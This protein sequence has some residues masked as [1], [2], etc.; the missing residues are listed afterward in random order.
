MGMPIYLF[1]YLFIFLLFGAVPVAYGGSQAR[2]QIGGTA[3]G[4]RHSHNN[5]RFWATSATYSTAHGNTGSL[6]QWARPGIEPATSW[7]LVWF[8]STVPQQ[9]LCS[10]PLSPALLLFPSLPCSSFASVLLSHSYQA[11]HDPLSAWY[12]GDFSGFTWSPLRLLIML[13]SF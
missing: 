6:T 12:H 9:E 13:N 1:I 11:L 7:F 5:A 2:D 10:L 4:L 3:A 8:V